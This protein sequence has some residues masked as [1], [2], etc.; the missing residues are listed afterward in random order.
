MNWGIHLL[1]NFMLAA[2]LT[3]YVSRTQSKSTL[4]KI[5]LVLALSNL[6]DMDHLLASPIYDPTRCSINFH[7]LHSW[8]FFPAYLLGLFFPKTRIFCMGIALH[9]GVDAIDCVI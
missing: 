5:F 3:F 6:I 4:L 7:P 9:L 2:V 1:S 8:Y